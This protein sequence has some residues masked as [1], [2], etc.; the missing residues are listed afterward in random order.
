[1]KTTDV[2]AEAAFTALFAAR[3]GS[4]RVRMACAMFDAAKLLVAADIRGQ[5]PGI[6]PADLR[7][8][9]F[10]RLYF[11]DFD[12]DTRSRLVAALFTA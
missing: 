1:M 8:Q 11:G 3:S 6:S 2:D 12:A 7:R 4:D 5:H 10:D 9:M